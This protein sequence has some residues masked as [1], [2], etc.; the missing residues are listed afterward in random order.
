MT[1]KH[2]LIFETFEQS[3]DYPLLKSWWDERKFPAPPLKF[4]PRTGIIVSINGVQM[5]AGFLFKTDANIAVIGGI[6]SDPKAP[7][8]ECGEAV[9]FVIY[10]LGMLAKE[11]GFEMVS[12]AT[13]LPKLMGRAELQ[14][15][16]KTDEGVSHFGRVF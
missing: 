15:F 4:L 12:M 13:N 9:D 5:A 10:A 14:G 1:S 2:D 16:Q 11:F 3:V 8:A 7:K 6:V